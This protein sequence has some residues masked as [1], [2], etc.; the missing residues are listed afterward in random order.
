LEN[1]RA[2]GAVK[3]SG[4]NSYTGETRR[5]RSMV[6]SRCKQAKLRALLT[7]TDLCPIHAF[8]LDHVKLDKHGPCH[9]NQI[10]LA[11]RNKVPNKKTIIIK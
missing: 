3:P 9:A 4:N 6:I 8:P 1:Q 10:M 7:E 5:F 2:S 11:R